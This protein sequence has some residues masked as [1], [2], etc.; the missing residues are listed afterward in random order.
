MLEER[1]K[2]GREIGIVGYE[3]QEGV[4]VAWIGGSGGKPRRLVPG[5]KGVHSGGRIGRMCVVDGRWIKGGG[6]VVDVRGGGC[7]F[8]AGGRC[9][10]V[11]GGGGGKGGGV[12]RERCCFGGNESDACE[13]LVLRGGVLVKLRSDLFDYTWELV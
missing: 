8:S 9:G 6:G 11:H 4:G 12:E 3:C 1:G 5:G 10:I 7:F 2:G 13:N